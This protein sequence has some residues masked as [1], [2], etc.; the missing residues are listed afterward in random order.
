MASINE[1][2][3]QVD[4]VKPNAYR[5][6][7]KFR[8]LSEV[9]GMVRRLVYQEEEAAPYQY[10]EDA[11]KPLLIGYPFEDVYV[12]YMEARIDY[13]N[14]E[15]SNYNNSMLMFNAK[16]D[17]YR[18]AWLREHMPKDHGSYKNVMG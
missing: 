8:W 16:F 11:D 13:A 7:E 6:E 12:H 17:E 3:E 5:E 10:P 4:A 14:R 1:I 18:K 9:D 2:I 15:Y